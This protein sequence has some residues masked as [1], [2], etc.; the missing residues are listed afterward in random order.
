[1]SGGVISV[2]QPHL[3]ADEIVVI[4]GGGFKCCPLDLAVTSGDYS[5]IE[6]PRNF[7]GS[8]VWSDLFSIVLS[9]KPSLH[10][11]FLKAIVSKLC[12]HLYG[13]TDQNGIRNH[14]IS[15]FFFCTGRAG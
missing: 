3:Y 2:S 15:D 1:M 6:S 14:A 4:M 12:F 13:K 7:H 10:C 5:G 9:T 11:S 8:E